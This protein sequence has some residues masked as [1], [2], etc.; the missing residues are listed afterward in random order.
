MSD[1]L[2]ALEESDFIIR[3]NPYGMPKNIEKYKLIDNFCLFWDKYVEPSQKEADFM[4]DNMTSDILKSWKGVAFEEVCW[5]HIPQIKRALEVGGVKS[6]TSIWNVHGDNDKEGV[7]IDLIIKRNDNVVNLC[8]MKFS[9]AEYSISKDEDLRLRKRINM[10]KDTLLKK[11]TVHLTMITTYG[12]C[13][14][15]YSGIVQKSLTID[16]FFE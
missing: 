7:Q 13:Q 1:T 3:Y 12:L 4:S 9:S 11:Q 2:K 16:D 10:L 8:E 14:N 6:S 5:Q 15:K